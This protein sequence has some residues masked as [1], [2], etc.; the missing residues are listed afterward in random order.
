MSKNRSISD[1]MPR[2]QKKGKL[3][4]LTKSYLEEAFREE[5]LMVGKGESFS[6]SSP[7]LGLETAIP[8]P[9]IS[10]LLGKFTTKLSSTLV[11]LIV[12]W[13]CHVYDK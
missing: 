2:K 13:F 6:V 7:L 8:F 12:L 4:T 1:W 11:S 5:N 9:F 3:E 10:R